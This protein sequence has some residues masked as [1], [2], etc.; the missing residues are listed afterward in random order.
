MDRVLVGIII[1]VMALVMNGG[2]LRDVMAKDAALPDAV[3]ST[4][5][6]APVG[7]GLRSETVLSL[8]LALEALRATPV[9]LDRKS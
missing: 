9:L 7:H 8:L 1:A 5:S 4:V 2:L 3:P 6:Q